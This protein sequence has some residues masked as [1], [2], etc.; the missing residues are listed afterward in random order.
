MLKFAVSTLV[1]LLGFNVYRGKCDLHFVFTKI[2]NCLMNL[3]IQLKCA[4][5]LV[6]GTRDFISVCWATI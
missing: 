1:I 5:K 6:K 2:K 3:N 4:V